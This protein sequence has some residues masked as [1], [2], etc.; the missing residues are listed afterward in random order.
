MLQSSRYY[1]HV[2]MSGGG[3]LPGTL[4]GAAGGGRFIADGSGRLGGIGA[5][6]EVAGTGGGALELIIFLRLELKKKYIYTSKVYGHFQI[7]IKKLPHIT[8]YHSY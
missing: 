1:T 5:A 6:L 8:F 7:S 4:G 2:G 3:K